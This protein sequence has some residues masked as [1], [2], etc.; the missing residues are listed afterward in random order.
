MENLSSPKNGVEFTDNS[1]KYNLFFKGA[2]IIVASIVLFFVFIYFLFFSAPD[3]FPNQIIVNIEK[4]AT[5]KSISEDLKEK[6]IIRSKVLFETIV[7]I[8]G[9]E[10]HIGEGDY[11]FENKL[12]VFEVARRMVK[13][14]RHL[15]P[16]KVTIPEGFDRLQL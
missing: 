9:G 7:I 2:I 5:L 10:N 12:P 8:Y 16:V 6:H 13:R 11:L 14:D 4:G 15:A 3:A 1:S